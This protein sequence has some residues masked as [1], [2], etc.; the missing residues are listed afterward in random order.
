MLL[1]L[2]FSSP[3]GAQDSDIS[4]ILYRDDETISQLLFTYNGPGFDMKDAFRARNRDLFDTHAGLTLSGDFTGDGRDEIVFFDDVLYKP[5]SNPHYTLS[6]LRIS[7]V[8]GK[9]FLPFG[10]W[11][12]APDTD[13]ELDHVDHAVA[14]DFDQDGL[15]DIALLY[16]DPASDELAIYVLR[17]T[18]SGFSGPRIW[19]RCLRSEF[20]FTAIEFALAGDFNG[21][22]KEDLLVFY[23]FFGTSQDTR[24]ALYLFESTGAFFAPPLAAYEGTKADYDFSD[25]I[26]AHSGDFN[27]DPFSDIAVVMEDPSGAVLRFLVYEGSAEG[28]L[29]PLSYLDLPF[30]DLEA[31]DVLH[32][33]S[34]N[35]GGDK[36][37][38]LALFYNN[39]GSGNQDLL[40]LENH[41]RA[42]RDP[43]LVFSAQ[44]DSLQFAQMSALVSGSFAHEPL[45]SAATWKYDRRGALSF[46]FD[47]GYRGAFEHGGAELEAAGLKGTFY[48]FTD[49]SATY[50]GELASTQLV[51]E[52]RNMGHEIASHTANHANLGLLTESGDL[53]SIHAVLSTSIELLNERFD[54][55]TVTM[56]IPFGSF[57]HE[58]LDVI[59]RHFLSARSSQHGFNLATPVDFFALKSWPV[60]S[61]TSPAFVNDL[62]LT[63]EVFGT[64]LPLM[65][66]ELTDDP[67]DENQNIYTYAR[68]DFRETVQHALERDLWIDTHEHIYK[69]I[70]E[71]NAFH[72]LDLDESEIDQEAGWFTFVADDGLNDSIF[73]VELSLKV[74]IPQSWENDSLTIGP[75]DN[76]SYLQVQGE[77]TDRYVLYG[78]LPVSDVSIHVHEGIYNST[79]IKEYQEPVLQVNLLAYPNPFVEETRIRVSGNFHPE[80]YLILRDMQGRILRKITER[81]GNSFRLSRQELPPGLYLIQLIGPDLSPASLKLLVI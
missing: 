71:R 61:L 17:S 21:N 28:Q 47:D 42:F 80:A 49:T 33:A 77:G 55:Q 58:T 34:G 10:S 46:T 25:M 20:N 35:F 62:M 40:V 53:D 74:H 24:Q 3:A 2:A 65:Y 4:A 8:V 59:S 44:P 15:C 26:Y 73:D 7:R 66:H 32:V 5:N 1:V 52:Y 22:G 72:I 81:E 79:G 51:R 50:G 64:Y 78:W 57:R 27:L 38:D 37:A 6:V 14:A 60:V 16:N 43:A 13:I 19:Y 31:E 63:C 41:E 48:I 11:F 67:F 12:S 18:G 75:V 29:S 39:P 68:D 30:S 54:Q 45:V 69:Y 23:N 56:S 70:R 36:A 76:L 9:E